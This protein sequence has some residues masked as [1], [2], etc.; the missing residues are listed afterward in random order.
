TIVRQRHAGSITLTS[1]SFRASEGIRLRLAMRDFLADREMLTPGREVSF[2]HYVF[3][4]L[5]G[6]YR[7]DRTGAMSLYRQWFSDATFR[8]PAGL[9]PGYPLLYRLA[10]FAG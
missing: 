2:R 4:Q 6:L 7:T 5:R 1:Q 9:P 8:L 3:R 10:G